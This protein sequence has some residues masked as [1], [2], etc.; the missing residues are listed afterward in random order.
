MAAVIERHYLV[1]A[2]PAVEEQT[3]TPARGA[4]L[5]VGPVR[6]ALLKERAKG[7]ELVGVLLEA[8]STLGRIA[9]PEVAQAV[10]ACLP[11]GLANGRET[12]IPAPDVGNRVDAGQ[13]DTAVH[14]SDQ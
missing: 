4:D 10:R 1:E 8:E 14:A 7:R 13:V 2:E 3:G 6:P 5:D 9:G 11:D 12:G